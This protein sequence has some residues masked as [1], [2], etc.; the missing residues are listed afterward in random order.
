MVIEVSW[1]KALDLLLLSGLIFIK[2]WYSEPHMYERVVVYL[3]L[4][5]PPPPQGP[6]L[7]TNMFLLNLSGEIKG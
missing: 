3:S 6:L 4:Q 7:K 2:I 5:P 1:E